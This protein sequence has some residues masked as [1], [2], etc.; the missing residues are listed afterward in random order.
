MTYNSSLF[1]PRCLL[2]A[3]L[4]LA[5]GTGAAQDRPAV[6]VASA[7]GPSAVEP[8]AAAAVVRMQT[9][10]HGLRRDLGHTENR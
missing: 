2:T 1:V 5:F 7:A 9:Y 3:S 8:E 6:A 10:V 4:L